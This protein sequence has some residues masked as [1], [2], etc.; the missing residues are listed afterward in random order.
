MFKTAS[1]L[2]ATLLVVLLGSGVAL[3]DDP[4]RIVLSRV[5]ASGFPTVH[6]VASVVDGSGKAVAGLRPQ[7]LEIRE[8]GVAPQATVTLASMVSPVAVV[9]VIDSSGSMAGKPLADAK[10]AISAMVGSLGAIDEVAILSFNSSV[11]VVEPLSSDKGRA[12]AGV[13]SI[14]AGGDTAIYDAAESAVALLEGIDPK[15][16]RAIILLTDGLDTASRSSRL[17]AVARLGSGG[18]PVYAIGL[19]SAI[20]RAR[21]ISLLAPATSLR[22]TRNSASS[23]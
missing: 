15:A 16:R 6:L 2:V 17:S 12:L 5:D 20:D 14:I 9:L 8:G 10:A 18:F 21:R 7:D 3:A 23:S 11:R 19:G 13:S 22:S 4:Y 1:I